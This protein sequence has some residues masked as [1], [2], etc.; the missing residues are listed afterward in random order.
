MFYIG[1]IIVIVLSIELIRSVRDIWGVQNV[2][3]ILSRSGNIGS[4]VSSLLQIK[5]FLQFR[6]CSASNVHSIISGVML[7][8]GCGV[9]S[10]VFLCMQVL[11]ACIASR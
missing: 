8:R 4:I 5:A 2:R 6:S 10:G 1:S 7:V 11:N 9:L 3:S